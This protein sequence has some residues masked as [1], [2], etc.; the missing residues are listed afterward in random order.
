MTFI[1]GAAFTIFVLGL[2]WVI[3]PALER[4]KETPLD[5]TIV[6][7]LKDEGDIMQRFSKSADSLTTKVILCD[8]GSTD[9]TK[10][11]WERY[12]THHFKWTGDFD[13]NRNQ[14]LDA[15]LPGIDTKWVLLLDADH[16]IV[17]QGLGEPKHDMN[18]IYMSPSNN[19]L[20]YLV[21]TSVLGRCRYKGVRHE[22]LDCLNVTRGDY[23]G[24]SLQH[25][26]DGHH[27]PEKFQKDL[28]RLT[29]A[30][31]YEG[32]PALR[33]R[34]AFYIANTHFDLGHYNESIGW[35]HK[36]AQWEGWPEEVF[37]SQYRKGLAMYYTNDTR[38]GGLTLIDSYKFNPHR[39]EPLYYLAL[40]ERDKEHW[41]QCLLYT[42]AGMLVASPA[43]DALFVDQDIYSWAMEELHAFCLHKSGRPGEAKIHWNRML[44]NPNLPDLVKKRVEQNLGLG[45]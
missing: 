10:I 32:D 28:E 3:P 37:F 4:F 29:N 11:L 7:M 40:M 16:T 25:H 2:A 13:V 36:R 33:I 21:R 45:L 27:R 39:K 9:N 35:Y 23:H 22:Y 8:T 42:R 19:K 6:T 18:Y 43:V 17:K 44:S 5:V 12:P 34:Y 31:N 24:L 30:F 20:P 1:Q 26:G 14:C 41:P 15:V 38:M